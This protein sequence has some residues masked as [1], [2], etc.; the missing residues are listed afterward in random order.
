MSTT[1][2][3]DTASPTETSTDYS[4][5]PGRVRPIV[6]IG[7]PVLSTPCREVTEFGDDLRELIND[8]FA[9]MYDAPGVGLAANQIGVD[10]QVFVIDCP[11]SEH[12]SLVG[13][14]VNPK[15]APLG[16]DRELELDDE[17]CLSIPG[18]Y[19]DVPRLKNMAVTGFDW[20]GVPITLHAHGRAARCLQHETDHLAGQLYIDRIP[21]KQRRRVLKEY[22]E[23]RAEEG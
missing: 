9:T 16:E 3:A 18:P 1:G 20:N 2:D 21:A 12:G 13:H 15:L 17:G 4:T 14:I 7:D 5:P 11:D 6:T 19:T 10:L 8:M 22:V 23:I